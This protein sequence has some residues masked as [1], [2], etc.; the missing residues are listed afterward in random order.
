ME[1]EEAKVNEALKT[2]FNDGYIIGKY[3]PELGKSLKEGIVKNNGG[4]RELGFQL[5]EKGLEVG[6]LDYQKN[7]DRIDQ[8]IDSLREIRESRNTNQ[9]HSRDID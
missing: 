3:R 1:N 8:N 4:L 5:F 9:D 6:G 7:R 2:T